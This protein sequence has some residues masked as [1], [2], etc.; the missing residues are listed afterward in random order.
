M[1]LQVRQS[2]SAVMLGRRHRL[3]APPPKAE[4]LPMH[5]AAVYDEP[6]R[7]FHRAQLTRRSDMNPCGDGCFG[8][9][10]C[11]SH[12][13]H[14]RH[15]EPRRSS[16]TLRLPF[17][18]PQPPPAAASLDLHQCRR[19]RGMIR[20]ALPWSGTAL[21]GAASRTAPTRRRDPS[22][23]FPSRIPQ[24]PRKQPTP[25]PHLI[26]QEKHSC[27]AHKHANVNNF[28]YLTS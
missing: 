22:A 28:Q 5:G 11:E 16:R 20:T 24:C 26:S 12:R 18:S 21:P 19:S 17:F 1:T 4:L 2:K 15:Y 8:K 25:L 7:T 23:A 13:W 27:R 9:A 10:T 6:G 14:V 3:Q